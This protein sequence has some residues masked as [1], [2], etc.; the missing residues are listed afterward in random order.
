MHDAILHMNSNQLTQQS[1]GAQLLSIVNHQLVQYFGLYRTRS[2]HSRT[3]C[4]SLCVC[5]FKYR[6]CTG[7]INN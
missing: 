5:F 1:G 3:I 4:C 2:A 7:I 6:S